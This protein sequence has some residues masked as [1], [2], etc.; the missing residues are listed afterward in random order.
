GGGGGGRGDKAKISILAFEVA[1]V[2]SKSIVL[3][4]S[5]SDQEMIRLRGEVI[6]AEGVLKLVSDSEAALLGLACREKLQDLVALAGS[7][8]RL[9][10]RCQEAALQGFEHVFAD[11][12]RQ[13]IDVSAL[14]FSAREM[15]AKVKKMERYIAS[16]SNLYQELEILADLEQAV[17]RIHEDDP[18]ASSQQ[19]DNLSALEHK[20]SWQRQEIKYLRD[21]SLWNRT[22]DKIVML[23]A[24]TICTIHGRIVSVF[25]PPAALDHGNCNSGFLGL[26]ELARFDRCGRFSQQLSANHSQVL[27]QQQQQQQQQT[28]SSGSFLQFCG[29]GGGGGGGG[30]AKGGAKAQTFVEACNG[31]ATSPCNGSSL[32]ASTSPSSG[33]ETSQATSPVE[34]SAEVTRRTSSAE[35]AVMDPSPKNSS[36]ATDAP[37]E[38]PAAI[39]EVRS[40]VTTNGYRNGSSRTFLSQPSRHHVPNGRL[41]SSR[42]FFDPKFIQQTA[43]SSTLGGSALALHYANVIIIV[44]KMVKFPQLVGNDARD[45]LYRMLPKSVR[46]GLRTR[47]RACFKPSNGGGGGEAAVL[48]LENS[49]AAAWRESLE[50]ILGWL[51]PLAHNM[52]RWQSEHNF[53]QQVVSRTNVLLLQTLFFA[54]QIKAEAAIVELLVG[55]NY[56]CWYEKEMK[57]SIPALD[58]AAAAAASKDLDEYLDWQF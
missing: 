38:H 13:A 43:P 25:G 19:R 35:V 34:Q 37:Q 40:F 55:L 33:T 14:E 32:G 28:V 16:T 54:D 44:E 39:Q 15:E 4:Q 10:K 30:G 6:R 31:S 20:I 24:R 18:E 48:R 49:T 9:G 27:S 26:G 57:A 53:E 21:M 11:I 12:L 50:E 17:R 36:P 56:L 58:Y 1:N 7:V 46:V 3:W 42:L 23:L 47:L 8:A 45:D 29:G 41:T 22:Y 2:M 52:I 5:L 51:A